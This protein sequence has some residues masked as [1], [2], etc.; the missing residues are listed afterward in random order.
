M[1]VMAASDSF[2]TFLNTKQFLRRKEAV[3]ARQTSPR[4]GEDVASSGDEGKLLL[5]LAALEP[6]L[7]TPVAEVLEKSGMDVGTFAA[8]LSRLQHAGLVEV[9]ETPTGQFVK[10]TESGA[11]LKQD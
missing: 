10:L 9:S 1:G 6:G 11:A 7:E 2:G 4:S 8:S 5:P 3:G